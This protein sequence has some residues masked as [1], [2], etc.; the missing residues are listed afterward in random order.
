MITVYGLKNCDSCR[1]AL[2]WLK[3]RSTTFDFHDVRETPPDNALM[4]AAINKLGVDTLINKRST[5]WRQLDD[6]ERDFESVDAA[7]ALIAKYPTLLKRPLLVVEGAPVTVG[8]KASE[9]AWQSLQG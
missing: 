8:F 2:A 4:G 1:R 9:D 7:I 6:R 5:T 3:E